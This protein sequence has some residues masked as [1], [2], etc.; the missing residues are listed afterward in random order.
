MRARLRA[1]DTGAFRE[2]FDE[3]ARAVY[4]HGYRLTGDRSLAEDVVSTAFLQAWQIHGRIDPDGGSMRP[5]LLG[6][7]TN[8]VRNLTRKTRRQRDLLSRLAPREAVPDFADEVAGRL[9]DSERLAGVSRAM[10]RLGTSEREVIALCVWAGLDYAGAAQALGV[11]VGTVRSR[12]SR[13]RRKLARLT[14][15]DGGE[16]EPALRQLT[17]VRARMARAAQEASDER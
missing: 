1:G 17:G 4:Q 14:T 13:A 15:S 10:R 9:D 16:P 5:W 3:H 12:L 11:P 2:L 7:A 8:V 6:I